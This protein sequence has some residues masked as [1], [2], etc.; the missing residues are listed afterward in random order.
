MISMPKY[1]FVLFVFFALFLLFPAC[2]PRSEHDPE[3]ICFSDQCFD[4]EVAQTFAERAEGL[5]FRKSL[6]KNAG[7]LFIF[8]E[9]RR[10]NFWMKDTFISLDIIWIDRNKQIVSIVP[11]ILPCTTPQCPV[12]TPDKNALYVLE[13]NAGVTTELGLK[14]GDQAVFLFD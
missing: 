1:S 2:S 14:V 7:M 13:V 5:Q 3:K 8:S 9:S 4:V 11:N 12:Y 6:D 10:H